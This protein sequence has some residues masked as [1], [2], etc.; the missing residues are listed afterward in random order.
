MVAILTG[1]ATPIIVQKDLSGIFLAG[2]QTPSG[3]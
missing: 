3:K 1:L 2:Y